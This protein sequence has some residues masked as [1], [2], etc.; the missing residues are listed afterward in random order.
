MENVWIF[1]ARNILKTSEIEISKDK[2]HLGVF[3]IRKG[4]FAEDFL[5]KFLAV[6]I[7]KAYVRRDIEIPNLEEG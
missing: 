4:E 1:Q 6:A 3:D 2:V 7:V 5:R